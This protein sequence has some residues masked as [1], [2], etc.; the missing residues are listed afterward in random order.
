VSCSE[1]ALVSVSL[2]LKVSGWVLFFPAFRLCTGGRSTGL[3]ARVP[4]GVWCLAQ[5]QVGG[6]AGDTALGHAVTH[7]TL[8]ATGLGGTSFLPGL[9]VGRTLQG[10]GERG[11]CN[12]KPDLFSS[13]FS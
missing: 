8:T 11:D 2:T 10:R 6:Y 1:T 13:A 12:P 7:P 4:R 5:T 9:P 3:A